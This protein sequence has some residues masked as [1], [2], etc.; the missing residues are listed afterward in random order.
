M[1][2]DVLSLFSV[3]VFICE[4]TTM[5][6]KMAEIMEYVEL[7]DRADGAKDPLER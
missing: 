4:P 5:H 2:A 1:G 7:L 6:Q 3:P